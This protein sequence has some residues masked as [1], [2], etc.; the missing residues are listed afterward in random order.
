MQ[1][2]EFTGNA[3]NTQEDVLGAVLAYI[4]DLAWERDVSSAIHYRRFKCARS[5]GWNWTVECPDFDDEQERNMVARD[6]Q[7]ESERG[8]QSKSI[9][10]A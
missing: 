2:E 6:A 4:E 10:V 7:Q 3:G 9:E 8:Q 1:V 5:Q